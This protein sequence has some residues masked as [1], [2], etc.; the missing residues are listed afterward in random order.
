M[1]SVKSTT[2][3]EGESFNMTCLIAAFPRADSKTIVWKRN[4]ET[5][6]NMVDKSIIGHIDY[7]DRIS[8]STVETHDDTIHIKSLKAEDRAVYTCSITTPLGSDTAGIF[9]RVKSKLQ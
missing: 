9:L 7:G 3:Y 8:F 5:I 2:V 6:F 1:K 4:E